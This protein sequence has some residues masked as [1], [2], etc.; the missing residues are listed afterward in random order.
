SPLLD[1]DISNASGILVNVVGGEDMSI[2]E[3][4]RVAEELQ[5]R[6]NQNAR[7][8]WGATVDPTME[9]KIRVMVVAT[10]VSSRQIVGRA[11]AE[12]MRRDSID[13]VR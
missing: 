11:T 6:V 3:A 5:E 12:E 13:I 10:G 9:N 8:I 4:E 7:I 1:V 2:R